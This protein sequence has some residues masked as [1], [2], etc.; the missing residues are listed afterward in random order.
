MGQQ[1]FTQPFRLVLRKRLDVVAYLGARTGGANEPQPG[2]VGCR[3]RRGDDFYDIAILEFG[4]QRH[5]FVV[6]LRCG[7]AVAHVAVN[8]VGKINHRG[9][10]RQGQDLAFGGENVDS[11]GEEVHLHVVPEFGGIPRFIL[12]IEQGLQPFGPQAL[13]RGSIAILLL[14]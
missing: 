11:V 7:G 9:A 14:V 12:D 5:L 3:N 8:G 1:L 6:D 10:A 2:R 4:A 13:R